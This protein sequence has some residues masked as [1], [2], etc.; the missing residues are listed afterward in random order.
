M[1]LGQK[2]YVHDV[3]TP[4]ATFAWVRTAV[5]RCSTLDIVIVGGS[6]MKEFDYAGVKNR[7]TGHV[8]ADKK[9]GFEWNEDKYVNVGWVKEKLVKQRYQCYHHECRKALD[10][11]FSIDRKHNDI[12]HVKSNCAIACYRC[13]DRSTHRQ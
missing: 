13:Q 1:S 11:E 6:M 2:I 12:A 9:K 3:G 8:A 7:I 5:S 4:M 10:E